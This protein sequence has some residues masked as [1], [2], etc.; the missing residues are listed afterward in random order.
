MQDTRAVMRSLPLVASVLGRRYGVKVQIGGPHAYTDG[1]IIHLP[2]LPAN[3]DTLL[4]LVRGYLDHESGHVRETDFKALQ[5]AALSPFEKH[6]WNI[7]E[8]WR[9]ENKLAALFPGCRQNLNWLIAHFFGA[10]DTHLAQGDPSNIL[11]W[12][13]LTVRSWDVPTLRCK[14]NTLGLSLDADFPGVRASIAPI[15][16]RMQTS[17]VSTE[18]AIRYAREI[19]S[20]LRSYAQQIQGIAPENQSNQSQEEPEGCHE[21]LLLE[22]SQSL[23]RLLAADA[24]AL[25]KEMGTTMAE[26]LWRAHENTNSCSVAVECPRKATALPA[27]AMAE[28]KAAST[29]LKTRLHGLLQTKVLTRGAIGHRGRLCSKLLHRTAV[30]DGRVFRQR[31]ERQGLSTAVHILL[32]SSGSMGVNMQLACIACHAVALAL[33]ATGV[34]VGLTSFPGRQRKSLATVSPLIRHGQKIHASVD[35]CSEGSTPLAEALWWVMQTML[36]LKEHRKVILIITDG[37]PDSKENT[38]EAITA[39]ERAGFEVYG[40]AIKQT[41]IQ[42]LLPGKSVSISDIHDLVP[43]MFSLLQKAMLGSA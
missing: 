30:C 39:A 42:T 43:A 40:L 4:P 23:Q 21:N 37:D 22:A 19:S 11:N 5:E 15:L 26:A 38:L 29:T 35:V 41:S 7:I 25:P 32:D 20:T 10:N 33:E 16:S 14:L 18:E 36:V 31:S 13:L 28:A 1:K 27:S 8:D 6:I 9:V 34:N 17:C 24:D 12:L 3:D 2:S